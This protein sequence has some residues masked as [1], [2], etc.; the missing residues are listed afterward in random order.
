M[1]RNSDAC[2]W[3]T[4]SGKTW[5]APSNVSSITVDYRTAPQRPR[6]VARLRSLPRSPQLSSTIPRLRKTGREFGDL[7]AEFPACRRRTTGLPSREGRVKNWKTAVSRRWNH[8]S[9]SISRAQRVRLLGDV[10]GYRGAVPS[11]S[12]LVR[13]GEFGTRSNEKGGAA[14]AEGLSVCPRPP[15]YEPPTGQAGDTQS[16][17]AI[18]SRADLGGGWMRRWLNRR[19][20][21]PPCGRRIER[22][23]AECSRSKLLAGSL[24]HGRHPYHAP[25]HTPRSGSNGASIGV[26][27]APSPFSISSST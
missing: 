16:H 17:E 14:V 11:Y 25:A 23:G 24:N 9:Y 8:I 12:G 2:L 1:G 22:G 20:A 3:G 7:A 19:E 15:E 21:R 18:E 13:T 5:R 4:A 6:A 27:R 26:R 10:A